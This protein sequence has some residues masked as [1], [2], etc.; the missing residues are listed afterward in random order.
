MCVCGG[1]G[2]ATSDS[3]W[4]RGTGGS[5]LFFSV[6]LY[7]FQ[8]KRLS[9]STGP[10]SGR[11]SPN[12]PLWQGGTGRGLGVSCDFIVQ[13]KH[14]FCGDGNLTEILYVNRRHDYADSIMQNFEHIL[15]LKTYFDTLM[16]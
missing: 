14:E 12:L 1:G 7:H 15:K 2:G 8:K 11:S 3:K 16:N 13:C 4:G 6:T 5:K 9:P 10:V